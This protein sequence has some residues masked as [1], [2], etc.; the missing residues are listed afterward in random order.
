MAKK[1]KIYELETF[2][3]KQ[4]DKLKGKMQSNWKKI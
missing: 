1:G 3:P 4:N 2:Y